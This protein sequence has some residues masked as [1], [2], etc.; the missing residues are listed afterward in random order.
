MPVPVVFYVYCCESPV[1]PTHQ[2]GRF[3]HT[4]FQNCHIAAIG[5]KNRQVCPH[6]SVA[7]ISYD[8]CWRSN[9][10]RS[11]YKI[12]RCVA[13]LREAREFLYRS[14]SGGLSTSSQALQ[15]FTGARGR[16][17]FK[18]PKEPL[19]F[20]TEKRF[21]AEEMAQL[22]GVSKRTFERRYTERDLVILQFTKA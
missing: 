5:E 8:L 17:V 19:E 11:A 18:I 7:K 10:P 15:I 1:K 6:Q 16:P 4:S 12:A 22:F 3:Y 9:S 2:V 20:L 13:G 21:T 14:R